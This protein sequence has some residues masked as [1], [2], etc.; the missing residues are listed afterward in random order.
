M[1]NIDPR[2]LQRSGFT[3]LEIM[4]AVAVLVVGILGVLALFP[5]ALRSGKNTIQ[6]TNAI[7]I[8]QS[9]EQAIRSGL[10]H[11]K[12]QDKSGKFTYF[13]FSHPGVK[14]PLPLEIDQARPS[15]DYYILLPEDDS[16]ARRKRIEDRVSAYNRGKVFVYPETDGKSWLDEDE[17]ELEDMESGTLPNGGGDATRADDDKNDIEQEIIVDG[18]ILTRETYEVMKTYSLDE[19]FFQKNEDEEESD[20]ITGTEKRDPI[21]D[22]SFCFAIRRAHNDASLGRHYPMEK[23]FVPANELFEVEVLVYRSFRAGT[24]IADNPILRTIF[25]IHK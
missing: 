17:R 6:D 15:S 16:D 13:I 8:T 21:R 5:V 23:A 7:I 20:L 14:D 19:D 24:A 22:Y 9:V 25:L 18:E 1:N 4:I 3:L 2:T 10:A 12:G 11:R